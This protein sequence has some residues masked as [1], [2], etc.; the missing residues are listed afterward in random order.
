MID[1]VTGVCA[2]TTAAVQRKVKGYIFYNTYYGRYYL[3]YGK[4][5]VEA[6]E[7]AHVY[8]CE[9]AKQAAADTLGWGGKAE[10]KWI[11]IYE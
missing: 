7:F 10:G 1:K 9:E 2:P 6:K 3:E 5:Q 11:V 4:G 8:S